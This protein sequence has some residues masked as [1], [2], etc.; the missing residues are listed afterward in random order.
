MIFLVYY[1]FGIVLLMNNLVLLVM[2]FF[3][4][5]DI[6]SVVY[7]YREMNRYY[8][9]L[10]FLIHQKF[11]KI[12]LNHFLL[13]EKKVKSIVLSS[14]LKIYIFILIIYSRKKNYSDIFIVVHSPEFHHHQRFVYYLLNYY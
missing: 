11:L 6:L 3:W 7:E 1:H 13:M 5:K 14:C 4:S 12:Y 10:I 8:L 9:S 2:M